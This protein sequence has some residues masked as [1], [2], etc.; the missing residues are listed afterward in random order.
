MSETLIKTDFRILYE[1]T[2][3]YI[4]NI[5]KDAEI[6]LMLIREGD[7]YGVELN[8]RTSFVGKVLMSSRTL[9]ED[10]Y[11]IFE[12]QLSIH[13]FSNDAVGV[14][15]IIFGHKTIRQIRFVAD[16][17]QYE[18]SQAFI[19]KLKIKHNCKIEYEYDESGD[20]FLEKECRIKI[21]LPGDDKHIGSFIGTPKINK[22]WFNFSVDYDFG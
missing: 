13:L 6:F 11:R 8:T 22:F 15:E 1:K 21:W 19:K 16:V 7:K 2:H 12:R 5:N 10:T 18:F 17:L 14:M 9:A 20:S 4:D 3:R